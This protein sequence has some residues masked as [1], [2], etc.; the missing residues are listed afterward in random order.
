MNTLPYYWVRQTAIPHILCDEIV[1]E[2]QLLQTIDATIGTEGKTTD[3]SIR[4][5]NVSWL[6]RNHWLEGIL[7]NNALY[8]N[9][10]AGWDFNLTH[11]EQVQLAEYKENHFYDW[12]EDTFFL[13]GDSDRKLTSIALLNDPSEFTGGEFQLRN[14]IVPPLSKGDIVVFP[15]F[16]TH[17]ATKILSGTRYSTALWVHGQRFK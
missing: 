13:S 5:T 1:K 8:A 11:C 2:K 4:K 17:R 10:E 14:T 6:P 15:S 16:L 9:K 3:D 7:H 12:H